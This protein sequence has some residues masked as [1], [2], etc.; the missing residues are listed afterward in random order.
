[1]S[2]ES[3]PYTF[4]NGNLLEK[5][6][7]YFYS[8]YKGPVF[9]S[10]FFDHRYSIFKDLPPAMLAPLPQRVTEPQMNNS[11]E[12]PLLLEYVLAKILGGEINDN[13]C[14]FW[15]ERLVKKFEVTKRIHQRYKNNFRAVDPDQHKNY[16]LYIRLSEVFEAGYTTS[17]DIRLL[18][19]LLKTIDTIC[20][21]SE[22][23][24]FQ[25]RSR[26]A[27]LIFREKKHIENMIHK[28]GLKHVLD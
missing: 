7:T 2:D 18:N 3:E 12:T 26:L 15:L 4:A 9:V 19:V 6:N 20:S 21:F 8:T 5:P 24:L 11:I 17:E 27:F 1:M 13:R 16:T 14:Q 25:D 10:S 28:K 23:L 22:H